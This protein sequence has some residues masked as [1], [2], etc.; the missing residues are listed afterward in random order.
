[1]ALYDWTDDDLELGGWSPSSR[2]K[3]YKVLTPEEIER[4]LEIQRKKEQR[5]R[6]SRMVQVIQTYASVLAL[7]SVRCYLSTNANEVAGGAPAWS[8]G[9]S[10]GFN[11]DTLP[12]LSTAR[13][14]MVVKGL[15]IHEI[16]HILFTA[17]LGTELRDFVIDNNY[18]IAYNILE[19][20]RLEALMIGRFGST[21]STWLTGVVAQYI[22]NQ[23]EQALTRIYP[24]VAGRHYLPIELRSK[25]RSVYFEQQ[26]T[27]AIHD[28]SAEYRSMLF[29]TPEAIDR[30]KEIIKAFYDLLEKNASGGCIFIPDPNGHEHR[31]FDENA[32]GIRVRQSKQ[33]QQEQAAKKAEKNAKP[34]VVCGYPG[35]SDGKNGKEVSPIE[36]QVLDASEITSRE[37]GA[38][39]E[40][41]VIDP[42]LVNEILNQSQN[43]FN[44]TEVILSKE[45]GNDLA[46]Y[47]GT[48]ELLATKITDLRVAS[49]KHEK[50]SQEAIQGSKAFLLELQRIKNDFMPE[51]ERRTPEGKINAG[52]YLL[53][54]D[55]DEAFDRFDEGNDE[56]ASIEAVII[57]DKSGSMGNEITAA[58]EAMWAIK[59]ALDTIGAST[60]VIT[61]ASGSEVLYNANEIATSEMRTYGCG[62]G[63]EP[64]AA[65]I[66]AKNILA[67]TT[68]PIKLFMAITDGE[69][70]TYGSTTSDDTIGEMR[71]AGVLTSL[72]MINH[73]SK[74]THNCELQAT[75]RG[76]GA[77]FP[78]AKDLVNVAIKRNLAHY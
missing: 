27:Q 29:N 37:A 62:G 70:Y 52:R 23:D 30:G 25:I 50:P 56:V 53:G 54:C 57:L 14:A 22:T 26:H 33:K 67:T 40:Q 45:L 5:D 21:I 71:G 43:L 74:E 1:M 55:L 38:G 76:A 66:A 32:G 3:N 69:W 63:T 20:H 15:A 48:A 39:G 28:L 60:S 36:E 18:S 12:D 78:L 34:E 41:E 16:G 24:I 9:G 44:D 72:V 19:D 31:P 17:R 4:Q 65:I 46:E 8:D 35:M 13:G 51:W 42:V 64:S 73:T 61:F 49:Y 7:Q 2:G 58:Y 68:R 47:S 11:F 59:R 10:I 77:L 6:A 75:I